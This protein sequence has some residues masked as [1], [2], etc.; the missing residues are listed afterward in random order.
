M[1]TRRYGDGSIMLRVFFVASGTCVYQNLG[2]IIQTEDKTFLSV[3][4]NQQQGW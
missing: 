1:Q 4:I 2:G 3:T